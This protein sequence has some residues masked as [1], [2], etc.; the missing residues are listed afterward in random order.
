MAC[1]YVK[2]FDF[3]PYKAGG[4]VK[5]Q[6]KQDGHMAKKANGGALV[7]PP[8][9]VAPGHAMAKGGKSC[10]K[11]GATCKAK[12]GVIEK[13]T[14]EKYPSREEMIKH[15]KKET[16]RM[17]KE[18]LIKSATVKGVIPDRKSV[19]VAPQAPLLALRGQAL[20]KGGKI[21][22]AKVGKVM[23]EFKE[24]K[25]HSGSKKGPEVESKKQ[26]LAIALSEGRKAAKKK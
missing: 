9:A 18:E 21:S 7:G 14:G 6:P 23:T 13:A 12:G 16:P 11:G 24:G 2:E 4:H 3:T 22:E 10:S 15:E 19:P 26:A 8:T 25:L 17:Q 5:P 1:K 20:K